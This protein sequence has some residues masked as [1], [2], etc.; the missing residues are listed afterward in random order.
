MSLREKTH[1]VFACLGRGG[2]HASVGDMGERLPRPLP[3][4]GPCG[5][6]LVGTGI[7]INIGALLAQ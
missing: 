6:A 5:A 2:A 7:L 1:A 4:A 3:R